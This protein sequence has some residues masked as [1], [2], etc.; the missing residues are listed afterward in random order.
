M[1]AGR[2]VF[3]DTNVLLSATVPA[4]LLHRAAL[5]V[6]NDWPNRGF[7]LMASGQVLREYLVVATRPAEVNGL[8]MSLA[9]ALE[10]VAAFSARLRL[11]G[12]TEQSWG[13][14]Q[15]LLHTQGCRGKQ[16]HDANIVA[17]AITAGV[18]SL[19]T[20]NSLDFTRWAPA[21]EVLDLAEVA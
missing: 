17:T 20:A 10:N 21:I 18:R 7:T 14:L 4:R 15:T 16:I 2:L 3:V 9:A 1:T 11:L 19:V 5:S 13:R 6:L 8:G 12:E